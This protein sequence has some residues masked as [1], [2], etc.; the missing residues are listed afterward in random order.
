MLTSYRKA[1]ANNALSFEPS[2]EPTPTRLPFSLRIVR[3]LLFVAE[4]VYA[5]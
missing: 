3:L 2:L 1:A 5:G 4:M